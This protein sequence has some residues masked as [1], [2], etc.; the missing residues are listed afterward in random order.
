M[1]LSRYGTWAHG[2]RKA[3]TEITYEHQHVNND[4]KRPEMW[5]PE[6]RN[7]KKY[8]TISVPC[9]TKWKQDSEL[10]ALLVT[11]RPW[12]FGN[13]VLYPR[14]AEQTHIH[15]AQRHGWLAWQAKHRV[16]HKRVALG[17]GMC[18][19]PWKYAL[20]V[21]DA[22]LIGEH[23]RRLH[24]EQLRIAQMIWGSCAVKPG[25]NRLY[26]IMPIL[27]ADVNSQLMERHQHG[28]RN[29]SVRRVQVKH[30]WCYRKPTV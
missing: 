11:Q 3:T 24:T 21:Y 25:K 26:G 17:Y 30:P 7:T 1:S 29:V 20:C 6:A 8:M 23:D 4:F 13:N 9:Q 18:R 5:N 10:Q 27:W 2:D 15:C 19:G 16:P 14:C 28:Q 12:P 22:N